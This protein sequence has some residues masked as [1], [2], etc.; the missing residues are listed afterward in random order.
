MHSAVEG[1]KIP[2]VASI[3]KMIEKDMVQPEANWYKEAIAVV[4]AKTRGRSD[5]GKHGFALANLARV[6][7]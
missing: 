5:E 1:Q 2:A 7:L 3:R 6:F 4:E